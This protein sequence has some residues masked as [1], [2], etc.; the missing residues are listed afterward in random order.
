[1]ATDRPLR[2]CGTARHESYAISE[3]AP[4]RTEYAFAGLAGFAMDFREP[5]PAP[6]TLERALQCRA[7]VLVTGNLRAAR[8]FFRD[9]YP[10]EILK[11]LSAAELNR[12]GMEPLRQSTAERPFVLFLEHVEDLDSWMQVALLDALEA[13]PHH[14]SGLQLRRVIST[15]GSDLTTQVAL[16]RFSRSL[17]LRL[18]TLRVHVPAKATRPRARVAP[19]GKE[20]C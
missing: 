1:V 11:V 16:G 4:G 7:N 6:E 13:P 17:F 5:S 10:G 8:R 3:G 9:A 12:L 2:G 14:A 19:E 20:A 18:S 15:G